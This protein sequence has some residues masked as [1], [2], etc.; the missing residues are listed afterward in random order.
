MSARREYK[1]APIEEALV[2]FRFKPA[3]GGWDW[4]IPGKLHAH[5][6]IRDVYPGKP[7]TQQ[8]MQ[9]TF[10]MVGGQP[11]FNFQQGIGGVHLVDNDAKRLIALAP[12]VVSV[13]VLRPYEGWKLFRPRV[14]T[15]LNAYHFVAKPEAVIRIGLRY[16][17]Q[18]VIPAAQLRL[19]DYF[20]A[21]PQ[22]PAGL[23]DRIG[24]FLTRVEY[25]YDDRQ[26][27]IITF[28]TAPS[29][30]GAS[31]FLLDLDAVWEGGELL[32][33]DAMPVVEV[34]KKSVAEAFEKLITNKTREVFDAG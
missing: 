13:H 2:E 24:S 16:V 25:V 11:A 27:L 19:A 23:P 21:P 4:T 18:I 26:K 32:V 29:Q 33:G 7:R 8:V 30:P 28:A 31:T 17:N 34:L 12:D 1:Q 20:T 15:V 3:P 6:A 5:E 9:N 10:Q 22:A 14:E